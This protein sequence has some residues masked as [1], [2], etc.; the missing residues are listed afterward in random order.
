MNADSEPQAAARREFLAA[1]LSIVSCA[2]VAAAAEAAGASPAPAGPPVAAKAGRL[3]EAQFIALMERVSN[4]GRWGKTDTLGALNLITPATIRRAQTLIREGITVSCATPIPFFVPGAAAPANQLSLWL[5]AADQWGA[6][7]DRVTLVPHGRNGMTHLD[8]L[9]HIY[10]RGKHY[11]G[12][13]FTGVLENRA[14]P[15]SI[16]AAGRGFTGRGVLI[17]LPAALGKEWLDPSDRITPEQLRK[18][19]AATGTPLASG[20]ILIFNTG[21]E[22]LKRARGGDSTA[23]LATGGLQI[24][25]VETIHS[26]DPALIISDAGMDTLPAEVQSVLIPWH[27][28]CIVMMGVQLVD[29][30]ALSEL[31]ATCRRLQRSAFF[32]TVAP[33]S[34]V[35]AT[36]SPVNPICVF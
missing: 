31:I 26:A 20:D 27:V 24:E 29:G 10:Y 8:A 19:I 34:F 9:A 18:A 22:A 13:P 6:V 5:D 11:N 25:C 32:C 1:A 28:A 16:E 23:P 30:A 12:V 7:N 36:A 17:D 2:A 15:M 3:S 33:V 35:G 21:M 14:G 4:W